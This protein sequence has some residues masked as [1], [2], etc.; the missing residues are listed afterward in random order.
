MLNII[1][2]GYKIQFRTTPYESKPIA[3]LPS[4]LDSE[5]IEGQI[6]DP[7]KLGAISICPS[8]E[9]Q[10]IYRVFTVE[11]SNGKD[12]PIIDLS[13]SRKFILER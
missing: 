3:S 10:H 8:V 2:S 9:G 7:L 13:K 6:L 12:R 1:S 5:I 4:K 11:N